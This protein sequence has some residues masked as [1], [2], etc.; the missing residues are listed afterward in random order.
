MVTLDASKSNLNIL[1]EVG[2]IYRLTN[3]Q[4]LV[5]RQ[6]P[7]F[8]FPQYLSGLS[9]L[10]MISSATGAGSV[11][12]SFVQAQNGTDVTGLA[13]IVVAPSPMTGQATTQAVSTS[14]FSA[15]FFTVQSA[16]TLAFP[17]TVQIM[18]AE[19]AG[20]IGGSGSGSGT[21]NITQWGG[22]AVSGATST[23]AVG[24]ESAQVSRTLLRK[25]TQTLTTTNIGSGATFTSAWFDT[26]G[27][28]ATFVESE[29][30]TAGGNYAA[31]AF[32][33][34][35]TDD[36]GNVNGVL[37]V[38]SSNVTNTSQTN[39]IVQGA[40]TCRFWRVTISTVSQAT[41][42]IEITATE[43]NANNPVVTIGG[44]NYGGQPPVAGQA[45]LV[46][47]ILNTALGDSISV[48][49]VQTLGATNALLPMMNYV[50][51]GTP[52]GNA[53]QTRTPAIFKTVQATAAGSTAL[54]TPTAGKKFRLMKFLVIV[55]G[56]ATLGAA[57]VLVIQL[58]DAAGAIGLSIDTFIPNAAFGVSDDFVS[59]WVDLGNGVLS[60]VANNVLNVNLSAALTAGNVRV[61]ACGT[62]E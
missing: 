49:Q 4:N 62:E 14:G 15:C 13:S 27:S 58:L 28:G 3:V 37:L 59:P 56:N 1:M 51:V 53:N 42:S 2:V 21:S 38:A 26:L 30:V 9:V 23:N 19:T 6:G 39:A 17:I 22:V 40:I 7:L 25:N 60:G 5:G 20:G 43:S 47:P 35:Q 11:G 45:V 55:T 54:W 24:T 29:I 48:G 12:L 52:T 8:W 32:K 46:T 50:C 44:N 31:G 16:G 41:T 34:Q 33:L 61:I 57:A 10:G 18:L 36:T